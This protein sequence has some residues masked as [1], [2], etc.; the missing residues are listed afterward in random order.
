MT[1]STAL[2]DRKPS[3]DRSAASAP[4]FH[5][6]TTLHRQQS[7][8]D[9]D[10][11]YRFMAS[12]EIHNFRSRHAGGTS[13]LQR[14]EDFVGYGITETIAENPGRRCRRVFPNSDRRH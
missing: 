14:A 7:Q 1:V 11:I 8:G 4:G 3:F 6:G 2:S 12:K 5:A 10:S 13:L 9:A